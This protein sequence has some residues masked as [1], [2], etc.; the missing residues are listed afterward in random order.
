MRGITGKFRIIH[1]CQRLF[2]TERLKSNPIV[3]QHYNLILAIWNHSG[4]SQDQLA[5]HL[6]LNKSSIARTV[7]YLE[8]QNYVERRI[9]ENDQRI[10]RVYPSPEMEK[11]I[12]L[13]RDAAR[14]WQKLVTVDLSPEELD[15]FNWIQDR[16]AQRAILAI[17]SQYDREENQ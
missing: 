11:V 17:D 9:C 6:R 16:I 8:K 5:R 3:A 7:A 15:Q 13:I 2:I 12:P 4:F 1:R 14:E 10:I